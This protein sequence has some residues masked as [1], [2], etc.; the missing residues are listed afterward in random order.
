VQAEAHWQSRINQNVWTDGLKSTHDADMR[1]IG[2]SIDKINT[3]VIDF[4]PDSA[5]LCFAVG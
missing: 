5:Y 4:P 2:E 3:V 1:N